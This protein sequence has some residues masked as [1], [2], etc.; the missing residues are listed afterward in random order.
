MISLEFFKGILQMQNTNNKTIEYLTS[1]MGRSDNFES[2]S[3]GILHRRLPEKTKLLSQHM[4]EVCVWW[5]GDI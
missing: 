2:W 1:R 5:C 3:T 4:P